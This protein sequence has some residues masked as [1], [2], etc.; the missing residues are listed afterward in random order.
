[1]AYDFSTLSPNEFE[2]LTRDLIGCESEI[3]FEAFPEGPDD[4]MDGRHA[5]GDSN[6]IL[7][8]KHYYR[9]G[10]SKLKSKMKTERASIDALK[11]KR[12]ILATSTPL[13]PK[14]KADLADIIGSSLQSPGDIFGPD[15]LNA[16]LRKFPDIEKAHSKLW[17][18]STGVM[19]S[20]MT[21]AVEEAFSRRG[22]TPKAI[23]S[24]L[25]KEIETNPK[26]SGE[27]QRNIVFIIKSS[28]VDDE[29]VLWLGPKLEAEGYQVFADILTLQP[30]DR[31]RRELNQVL[32]H[33]AVKVLLLSRA[34]TLADPTVQDDID[35]AVDLG[36]KLEDPRFIIPLRLEDGQKVKGSATRFQ[37]ISCAAGAKVFSPL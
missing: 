23:T 33:R 26:E 16:L 32:E 36:K 8:A 13:T 10:L 5:L 30:G 12:Y 9:S 24:V 19:K 4:G 37:L 25:P 1:M 31:W 20:V 11:A 27:L 18:Q 7:Q 21:E 35:I 15:D 14:N 6:T 22:P 29:F 2:E 28:P 3:R 34:E 17:Q